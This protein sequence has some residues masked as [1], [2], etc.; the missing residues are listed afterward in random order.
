MIAFLVFIFNTL[1]GMVVVWKKRQRL[2]ALFNTFV[3]Y[4]FL[5]SA[6]TVVKNAHGV[7]LLNLNT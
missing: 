5:A 6:E 4:C 2:D 7:C 3:T 1:C